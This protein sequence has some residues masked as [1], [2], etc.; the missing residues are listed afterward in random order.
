MRFSS[1]SW[2]YRRELPN[3]PA[4]GR[5][6]WLRLDG[7]NYTAELWLNGKPLGSVRGAFARGEFDITPGTRP[8]PLP[9]PKPGE[10]D[11]LAI[12]VH[13]QPHA[14]KPH[15]KSLARG[16]GGNGGVT[17]TDGPT[18][19]SAIGWDWIPTIRDRD[20]GI[21]QDIT[22]ATSGPVLVKDP[23]VRSKLPLP[24]TDSAGLTVE[25]TLVNA[26]DQPQSG[27]LAGLVDGQPSFQ[28]TVTLAPRERKTIVIHPSEAP[29]LHLDH[30]A[31]W[32]PNGY[33]EPA[34]H[35]LTLNFQTE[36]GGISDQADTTFGIRDIQYAMHGSENLALV[37]NGVPVIAKGGNWG[38]DEAM[39]RVPPERL[40]A[41]VRMHRQANYTII[42]NWVGQSTEEDFYK[43]CDRYGILV[44]DEMF[45]PSPYDGPNPL[46]PDLYLLNVKEKLLR[47]RNH[48]SV[49][50]WCGRNEGNPPP[51][52][53]R[54][55]AALIK[56]YDDSRLYQASST[57]GRGVNSGGPYYWRAP[58]E[59]YNVDAP[60]KTEIGSM[61][62]PTFEAVL[63]MLPEHSRGVIDEVWAERDF[64]AGAQR[65]DFF[66]HEIAARYGDFS[67]L[68]DF[69]RKGNLATYESYR[70]MYEGRFAKLFNPT[71]GV[72][73]WMS[74]P[75]QPSFVWQLYSHDLEPNAALFA[76]R[77][78]CEPVHVQLNQSNGHL[79]VVN[80]RPE[81][82]ER[83]TL[84]A[85]LT[86]LDGTTK[87]TV[88]R[89]IDAAASAVTDTGEFSELTSADLSPAHFV[90]LD[91]TDDTG[92]LISHS[93]YWH[94]VDDD[95]LTALDTLPDVPV[96]VSTELSRADGV[97]RV[98]SQADERGQRGCIDDA[99]SVTPRP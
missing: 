3:P 92:K 96:S 88:R 72:I 2:W 93:F 43:A 77:S 8:G 56:Q 25:A 71:T 59:Y 54:G 36:Q 95:N 81:A 67:N 1:K 7:I 85:R 82:A 70:A 66:P 52:I 14:G 84:T 69:V 16:V 22:L 97:C 51:E 15:Q 64:A 65:G 30:P 45:Q 4:D 79:M 53:S 75:A 37:V 83:L 20:T 41:M 35:R 34:L 63:A 21:W 99:Y 10:P 47:F 9:D 60:F 5:K 74:N 28:Q 17:G 61:S 39:K 87:H 29:A 58:R 33:G 90:S 6:R 27:T 57:D 40:D 24:R 18:F 48:P 38:M 50:L 94:G 23:F 68:A 46:D 26:T 49:A 89:Q 32:W 98:N 62:I 19:L 44:W 80:N 78:A 91:L 12:L 86:N 76:T 13:P 31:L 55:I 11:V 73:T 42:R